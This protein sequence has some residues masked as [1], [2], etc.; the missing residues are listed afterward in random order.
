[1]INGS[2]NRKNRKNE[3]ISQEDH[4]QV[5][6]YKT[7]QG[8]VSCLTRFLKIF[9][10]RGKEDVQADLSVDPDE[11]DGVDDTTASYLKGLGT[12]ALIAGV[13]GLAAANPT[14]AHAAV[15]STSTSASESTSLITNESQSGSV[16]VKVQTSISGSQSVNASTSND[17]SVSVASTSTSNLQASETTITSTSI[18][19][20]SVSSISSL[21]EISKD[22]TPR[23]ISTNSVQT[24][25]LNVVSRTDQL[26]TANLA[27]KNALQL[28]LVVTTGTD[29]NP[30]YTKF[31]QD[32]T[33]SNITRIILTKDLDLSNNGSAVALSPNHDLVID[34]G[35]HNIYLDNNYLYLEGGRK[36]T[37]ENGTVWTA[38]SSDVEND[39]SK[40]VTGGLSM[41]TGKNRIILNN[42]TVNGGTAVNSRYYNDGAKQENTLEL[43]GKTIFNALGSYKDLQGKKIITHFANCDG[44]GP[45][46]ILVSE[47]V[48]VDQG[49]S[50][51]MNG[52]KLV[53][54]N[55]S[56]KGTRMPRTFEVD[57]NLTATGANYGN[58]LM[59]QSW[60]G[61]DPFGTFVGHHDKGFYGNTFTINDGA[62]VKLE[63]DHFNV[64]QSSGNWAKNQIVT[65]G[66]AK[67]PYSNEYKTPSGHAKVTMIVDG[68]NGDGTSGDANILLFGHA[69]GY[70]PHGIH[71]DDNGF[72]LG[73]GD[74]FADK[75]SAT[76]T[77]NAGANVTMK[78]SG[79][80]SNI[81]SYIGTNSNASAPNSKTVVN[82]INPERVELIHDPSNGDFTF[83][84]TTSTY[85]S[86]QVHTQ[87][88]TDKTNTSIHVA[89]QDT[90][91]QVKDNL[92][93]DGKAANKATMLIGNGTRTFIGAASDKPTNTDGLYGDQT[94]LIL[95]D[96]YYDNSLSSYSTSNSTALVSLTAAKTTSSTW[97][98]QS[99][100]LSQ[101]F[102]EYNSLSNSIH[103]FEDYTREMVLNGVDNNPD[104]SDV[105]YTG[106]TAVSTSIS[107]SSVTSLS[108]SYSTSVAASKL[109]LSYSTSTAES[110][111]ASRQLSE[112]YSTSAETSA[113]A[114]TQLSESYSTSTVANAKA[115]TSLSESYSTS[116]AASTSA[117]TS[118]SESYSTSTETSASASTQLSES[119]STSTVASAQASTSLS[120]SY[121]TSAAASTNASTSLESMSSSASTSLSESYSTSAETSA[122][123][124]TQL[125]ESYSTSTVASAQASTSLSES[126]SASAAASTSASASLESMSSSAST[127][128]SES[129][130]TSAETSASASTQLSESYSASTVASTSASASLESMSSSASMSLSES[131]SISTAASAKASTSLS[132][133]YS[134]SAA[135]STSASASLESMSSSASMSLSESYSTSAETSASASTQ[136]SE[137]YSASMVASTSA[138]ASLESMSSSA[139]TSLSE[140]YSASAETSTSASA[141]LESMSSSAS[142][143]LSESYSTS[144]AASAQASTSLSESYSISAVAST[145]ISNNNERYATSTIASNAATTNSGSEHYNASTQASNA[146]T[147]NSGSEQYNAS[148]IASNAAM[149][150]DNKQHN[151]SLETN[152]A[153]ITNSQNIYG[154]TTASKLNQTADKDITSKMAEANTQ[155]KL[156][157]TGN[158]KSVGMN[159]ASALVALG[160]FLIGKKNDSKN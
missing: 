54:Y 55:V 58:V 121:S 156:P 38:G 97:L 14:V 134:T 74:H 119:Y 116:A 66:T 84:P 96:D 141:S 3:A 110:I 56:M 8:W 90:N 102:V 117:S 112:S 69:R 142:M 67:D 77:I 13:G 52:N 153:A 78:A 111:S 89:L 107:T 140:S 30:D 32:M 65:I 29:T 33:N 87:T 37:I 46:Q 62:T 159:L 101:A 27:V 137:S 2:N 41:A 123:A 45:S 11:L 122:S 80:A 28:N 21:A 151:S 148:T 138:S 68:D 114:S 155:K 103:E 127:S 146:A 95:D 100:S 17:N 85:Y 16:A 10:F 4:S 23:V 6:M 39:K 1:M 82:I 118:L 129:Y 50:V 154:S 26:N 136:L 61:N 160:A 106:S 132:E 24:Q 60:W 83:G 34:A 36:I 35:G 147:T 126:Y 133:S 128:L 63:A 81:R 72:H 64:A 152:N 124:S 19:S 25:N 120:E 93:V 7:H 135:A 79:R 51:T 139:S 20:N 157:S 99:A 149:I 15:Q 158:T 48:I 105:V 145:S 71:Q 57:G 144:T 18:V 31:S 22:S 131:Y 113:S 130:S 150:N 49:A 92:Q 104:A 98:S 42:V 40:T 94:S 5:K 125:S 75:P 47:H 86:T 88:S 109:S 143:S 44:Q 73:V 9:S 12:T 76:V 115:S 59:D 91:L 43:K 108:E 53:D 70:D